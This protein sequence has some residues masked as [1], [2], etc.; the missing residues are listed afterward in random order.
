M[1]LDDSPGMPTGDPSH[2]TLSGK[3]TGGWGHCSHSTPSGKA[4]GGWSGYPPVPFWPAPLFPY[5][6]FPPFPTA[7]GFSPHATT[8]DSP[9]ESTPAP[10]DPNPATCT[11]SPSLR[12]KRPQETSLAEE[13]DEDSVQLLEDAEALELIKFDPSVEPKDT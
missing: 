4:M 8:G 6:D 13:D 3:F 11:S 9:K 10:Q 7:W 5:L 12:G 2:P 1:G